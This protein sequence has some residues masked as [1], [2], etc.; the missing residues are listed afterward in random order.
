MVY[1]KGLVLE[2][3]LFNNFISNLDGGTGCT[4]SKFADDAE[5]GVVVDNT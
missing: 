1:L 2:T 4:L 3:M 5:L